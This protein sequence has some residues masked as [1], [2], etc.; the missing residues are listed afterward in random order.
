M[1][2]FWGW[3]TTLSTCGPDPRAPACPNLAPSWGGSSLGGSTV[4]ATPCYVP[5]LFPVG[6]LNTIFGL[7]SEQT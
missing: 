3:D 7:F 5:S 4:E 1:A 2:G 6:K